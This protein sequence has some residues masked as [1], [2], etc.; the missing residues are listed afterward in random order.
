VR[1]GC[2][3]TLAALRLLGAKRG[4][5]I[6]RNAYCTPTFA[7]GKI[8]DFRSGRDITSWGGVFLPAA[9]RGYPHPLGDSLVLLRRPDP[10]VHYGWLGAGGGGGRMVC[11]IVTGAGGGAVWVIT[12]GGGGGGGGTSWWPN[13]LKAVAIADMVAAAAAI[14]AVQIDRLAS[15]LALS[16]DFFR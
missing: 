5:L 15:L 8:F 2:S 13:E 10:P 16:S 4:R 14:V 3:K 9:P 11:V 6:C 7:A 1:Q 12:S